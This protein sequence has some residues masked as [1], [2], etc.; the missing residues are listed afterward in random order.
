[1]KRINLHT[2]R[3]FLQILVLCF[4]A[5]AQTAFGAPKGSVDT[6]YAIPVGGI[7][8][9][10]SIKGADQSSPVLLF[11]HGGPGNSVISYADKFTSSLQRHFLVVQ[12][13]QRESGHT[14][15]LNPSDKPLTVAQMEDDAMEV[16]RYL[17]KR[18]KK[19][20]IYLMGHSWGG[21]LGLEIAAHHPEVL[22][23]YIA[24][25]PMVFQT[26]SEKASLKWMIG[27]AKLANNKNAL[28]DLGKVHIPFQNGEDLYYHRGW[29]QHFLGKKFPDKEFVLNWSEK[30]LTLF[31]EASRINFFEEA[32]AIECPIYFFAG[33]K[34]Y[35][36]YY[37][38]TED[39]Y[40]QVRAKKKMFF[41]FANSAHN[42]PTSE[43]DRLQ[44]T[45]IREVLG[46]D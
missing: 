6:A 38:L 15:E 33:G 34:D 5:M 45:I 44:D 1:M 9:W 29:L 31:N 27:Q 43:P 16:I 24:V 37:R 11:L 17:K 21:F 18:F 23:A 40:N 3:F 20:R 10:L 25:C 12:W 32:P 19:Q 8:Q 14:A 7:N 36:T 46:K 22:E 41:L 2:S 39:Y 26:E 13:D 4:L 28:N 42:L 30:W 35:Q